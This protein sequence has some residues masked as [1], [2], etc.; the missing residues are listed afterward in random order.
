[1][2]KKEDAEEVE[3]MKS[4]TKLRGM[5]KMKQQQ[6]QQRTSELLRSSQ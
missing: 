4:T 1:M 2:K 3:G 5:K 6:Q